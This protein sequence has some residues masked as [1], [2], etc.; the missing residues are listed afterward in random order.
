MQTPSKDT[1]LFVTL[2]SCIMVVVVAML[3][4]VFIAGQRPVVVVVPGTTPI[5]TAAAVTGPTTPAT[6]PT[7]AATPAPPAT[8]TT[9]VPQ[10]PEVVVQRTSLAPSIDN[11][12]DPAWNA[13]TA[14]D[15]P[16]QPQQTAPPMLDKATIASVKIQAI[17][18]D[19]RIVWRLTWD[20]PNPT[21]TVNVGRFTDA[22][23]IQIPM[24]DGAPFTMG[25]PDMPVTLLYWRALWQKDVDE[26]FQDVHHQH[27]NMWTDLYWFAQGEFPFPIDQAFTDERSHEWLIAYSAGNPMADFNRRKS[28][29]EMV[30]VG[31][32]SV[33]NVP[34]TPSAA[35]GVWRDGKWIVVIDRPLNSADPVAERLK[36]GS[37]NAISVAL[38]DG[39]AGNVGG[40]KHWCNWVPMKVQP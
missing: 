35:N 32:G 40:R 10:T 5:S 3:A 39:A 31:F 25:A 34:D 4:A 22:V 15:L 7:A 2:L 13:V 28:V 8:P 21:D 20:Q 37:Q 18:D 12:L 19:Q 6:P 9:A 33:T 26:G 38:W 16:L 17:R 30:A 23:A 11:P 29:E 14:T 1:Y 24:V 27:P 36:S